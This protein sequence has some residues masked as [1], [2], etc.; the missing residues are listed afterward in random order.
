MVRFGATRERETALGVAHWDAP[1]LD[2]HDEDLGN[3]EHTRQRPPRDQVHGTDTDNRAQD[4]HQREQYS[5]AAGCRQRLEPAQVPD[6]CLPG[7]GGGDLVALDLLQV[8]IE[9]WRGT[10]PHDPDRIGE[11]IGGVGFV[12]RFLVPP[13]D[14]VR[15]A[16]RHAGGATIDTG[17]CTR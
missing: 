13:A 9:Q 4:G 12:S 6:R 11:P 7:L 15:D 16:L 2:V 10:V 14:E 3:E 8:L 5:T 1:E 17:P